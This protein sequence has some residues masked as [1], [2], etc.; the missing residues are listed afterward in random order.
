MDRDLTARTPEGIAY[1]TFGDGQVLIT[2]HGG[3]GTDHSFFRPYLDPL[4]DE[5][6]LIYY[7]L[8]G[9]GQST[10]PSDYSLETM[11]DSIER[12]RLVVG[13][14]R[15]SLLGSSYGGFLSLVY[16]LRYP[17]AVSSL[18]L[19]DTSASS[20]FREESLK[21][22]QERATPD[23][24]AALG[25]LWDGS[26]E[27][28]DGFRSAWAQILPLYFHRLSHR[29]IQALADRSTYT[30]D[31]RKRILPTLSDYDVRDRLGEFDAP[32]LVMVGRHD[33]I[34][35]VGQAEELASHSTKAELVV[36]EESGHYPFIEENESFLRRVGEW[37][38][39]H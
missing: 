37:I 7:D 10:P 25:R 11:A 20:G 3:P 5:F 6:Q 26:I 13:G 16:A 38:K 33:W 27:D 15:V 19:V 18:V 21:N 30:L 14:E 35:S 9:H 12:V 31:T 8:P 1:Q 28:D 32:F 29:E 24:L 22:A 2:V 17:D 39:A 23:M 36:F 34:T 4:A